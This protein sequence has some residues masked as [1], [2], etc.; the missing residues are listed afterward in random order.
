MSSGEGHYLQHMIH[1]LIFLDMKRVENQSGKDEYPN[2]KLRSQTIHR[3]GGEGQSIRAQKDI[4]LT[5]N[6]RNAYSMRSSFTNEIGK[7]DGD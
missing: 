4:S 5:R 2:R 1:E 7:C 6:H 3:A